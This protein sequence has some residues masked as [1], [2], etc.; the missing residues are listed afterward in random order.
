MCGAVFTHITLLQPIP[1]PVFV[2]SECCLPLPGS[3]VVARVAVL[4]L[5]ALLVC[6]CLLV[7][8]CSLLR[9]VRC[10]RTRVLIVLAP[11]VI[12][13]TCCV[14]CAVGCFIVQIILRSTRGAHVPAAKHKKPE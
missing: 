1:P 12:L 3:E 7:S 10:G 14:C 13:F 2:L 9:L 5:L 4:C 6:A 8:S 11:H